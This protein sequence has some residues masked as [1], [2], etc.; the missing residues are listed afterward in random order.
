MKAQAS[1]IL[2]D[3]YQDTKRVLLKLAARPF[4]QIETRMNVEPEWRGGYNLSI[5]Y[6][7]EIVSYQEQATGATEPYRVT[8]VWYANMTEQD[9]IVLYEAQAHTPIGE[10][11]FRAY[12]KVSLLY[13]NAGMPGAIF[14]DNGEQSA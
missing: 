10:L 2:T 9:A 3:V 7:R 4:I 13:A 12:G 5:K 11:R 14:N 6:N 1:T 8:T